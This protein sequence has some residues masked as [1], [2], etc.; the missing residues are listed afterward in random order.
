MDAIM[1]GL[2]GS[3]GTVAFFAFFAFLA[4]LDYRKKKDEREAAHR[5][6][7]EALERGFPP[8]D[9]E[10]ER[11]RAYASAAWAAGLVGLLV[12]LGVLLLT[13]V[14]TI[15]AVVN[16]EPGEN[17]L[18]PLIVGWSIAGL[19]VLVAVVVSLSAIRRLPR[20]TS[21]SQPRPPAEER[22]SGSSSSAFQEKRLEL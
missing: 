6:R 9:A 7:M 11:A 21:E 12:P 5:E 2:A 13:A 8:L 20:P 15:V 4:W 14:A 17:L 3:I 22:R 10:I 18:V 16:R 19:I 1:L